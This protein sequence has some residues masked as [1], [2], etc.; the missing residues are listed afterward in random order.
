MKRKHRE[1]AMQEEAQGAVQEGLREKKEKRHKVI[2]GK[3]WR[4]LWH[5]NSVWSWLANILIAFLLIRFIIYPVIGLAMGTS[6]PVVAVVSSSMEHHG[7]WP[8]NPA[9]CSKTYCI[10]EEWYLEKNITPAGFS[11]F[12]FR[13]G[14]NKGDIMIIVGKKPSDIK[15]GEVIVFQAGKN[16]PIIH[17]VIAIHYNTTNNSYAFET[18][19]DNNPT[20]II[21]PNLNE[22]HVQAPAIKG[23]AKARV[24]YLGY[25]KIGAAGLINGIRSIL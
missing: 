13:N 7:V 9:Y 10:Q 22:K 15:I 12:P 17:R 6:L 5:D 8:E 1:Q 24:P 23:V 4:F 3:V 14:F 18:K 16:Y 19:G 21:L 2:A 11:S 20:Q 25:I